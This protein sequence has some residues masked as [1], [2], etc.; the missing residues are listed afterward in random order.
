MP[1]TRHRRPSKPSPDSPQE[2]VVLSIRQPHA[3]SIIFGRGSQRKWVENRGWRFPPRY[4][5]PL[6]IHASRW[7]GDGRPV[8]TPGNGIVGAIIGRVDLVE[9]AR[10]RDMEESHYVHVGLSRRELT[11]FQKSLCKLFPAPD[12][13]DAWEF[14]T[15][16]SVALILSSPLALKHPIPTGGK[17]NLW[18]FTVEPSRLKFITS[19][20]QKGA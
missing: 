14:W 1:G 8:P 15:E 4:R 2:I 6:Y 13:L 17:L 19:K 3:D 5:G 9:A 16:D 7:D 20:P 12:D 10:Q 11:A 18:R